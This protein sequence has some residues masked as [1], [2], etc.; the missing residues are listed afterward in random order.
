MGE[1]ECV[2]AVVGHPLQEVTSRGHYGF[3]Y[4]WAVYVT[5]LENIVYLQKENPLCSLS[6]DLCVHVCL[7]KCV[8]VCVCVCVRGWV[9]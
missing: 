2:S 1:S 7:C 5:V 6:I 3:S 9:G 4:G 8:C